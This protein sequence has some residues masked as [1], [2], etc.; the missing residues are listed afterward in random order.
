MLQ[1][2][3]TL[4]KLKNLTAPFGLKVMTDYSTVYTLI[5]MD[6]PHKIWVDR[7][8]SGY[9]SFSEDFPKLKSFETNY[10]MA[11]E[12]LFQLDVLIDRSSVEAFFFGGLYSMTNLVFPGLADTGIQV[13]IND[14]TE[15]QVENLVITVL[16]K[17]MLVQIEKEIFI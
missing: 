8:H 14:E 9:T 13:W 7:T 4:R 2:K 17:S 3:M 11:N 1:V 16:E 12:N 10:D 15:I 6:A 5:A